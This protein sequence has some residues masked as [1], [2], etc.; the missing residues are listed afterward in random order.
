MALAPASERQQIELDF[1]SL[2]GCVLIDSCFLLAGRGAG[3]RGLW[4][5]VVVPPA[6]G[7]G[8]GYGYGGIIGAAAAAAAEAAAAALHHHAAVEAAVAPARRAAERGGGALLPLGQEL[9]APVHGVAAHARRVVPA[10]F[11]VAHAGAG[12]AAAAP[13]AEEHR[14]RRRR[15]VAPPQDHHPL[16]HLSPD[17]LIHSDPIDPRSCRPA[18]SY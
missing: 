8:C 9:A 7:G 13:A 1:I 11:P 12:G 6:P 4:R 18:A 15:R 2:P 16:H 5:A 10:A 14:R 17:D 3:R